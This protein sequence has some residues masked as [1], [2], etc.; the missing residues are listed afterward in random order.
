MNEITINVPAMTCG[1][2]EAAVKGEIGKLAEVAA[3]KV[4]LVSKDVVVTGEHLDP[5]AI[6]AAIEE[7]GFEPVG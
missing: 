4:D 5:V 3:V 2:C 1:H 7:A 6:R